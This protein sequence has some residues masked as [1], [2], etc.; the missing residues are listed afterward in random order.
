MV[1]LI[2][3]MLPSSLTDSTWPAKQAIPPTGLISSLDV[4]P[5]RMMVGSIITPDEGWNPTWTLVR[6]S[7]LMQDQQQCRDGDHGDRRG[8]QDGARGTGD[9]DVVLAGDDKDVGGD[10]EGCAEQGCGS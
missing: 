6:I 8:D 5:N 3:A 1:S 9:V 7:A 10:G 2:L 4:H